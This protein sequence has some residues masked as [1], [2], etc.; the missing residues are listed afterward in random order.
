[1]SADRHWHLLMYDVGDNKI[2]RRV[3]KKLTEWGKPV[4]Y[5]VF[6]V[7]CTQRELTQLRFE[8]VKL[9]GDDD[10]LLIVRLCNGCA[11]RVTMHG[12]QFFHFEPEP[13]PFLI[14]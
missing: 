5:S 9:I 11:S 13:P 6:R 1:M 4:Q 14:Y 3:H 2:L 7:R 8:L 10:R 12:K